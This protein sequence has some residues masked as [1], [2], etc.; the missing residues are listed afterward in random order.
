MGIIALLTFSCENDN[1]NTF[2]IDSLK[3]GFVDTTKTVQDNE[4]VVENI[5]VVDRKQ[6]LFFMPSPEQKQELF[7]YYGYYN[8][9][10]MQIVFQ[11]F[12][13]LAK[14][15]RSALQKVDIESE[16]TYAEKFVFITQSDTFVVDMRVEKQIFGYILFDGINKPL[17][18]YLSLI[19]I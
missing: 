4:E 14:N 2:S 6:A 18:K 16:I 10:E 8:Q 13:N 11:N 1:K 9:Y 17:I 19:H 12:S 15:T 3:V 7:K 5:R